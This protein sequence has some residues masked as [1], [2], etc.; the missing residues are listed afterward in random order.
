MKK[1][2][3]LFLAISA[4]VFTSC[5][6]DDAVE[7]TIQ[8]NWKITAI[9]TG[10]TPESLVDCDLEE[11]ISFAQASGLI[12]VPTEDVAPCNLE[13]ILFTYTLTGTVLNLE[14]T[15]S[16]FT[17]TVNAIVD[18]LTESTLVLRI[19]GNSE[20]GPADPADIELITYA[21]Q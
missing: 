20:D 4:T 2:A 1:I 19:I 17:F 16:G 3:I 8:G 12:G 6:D 10:G 15:D 7:A 14:L 11:T 13:T 21:R 9:S 5:G 18:S